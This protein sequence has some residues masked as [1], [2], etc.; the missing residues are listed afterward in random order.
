MRG[1]LY[2]TASSLQSCPGFHISSNLALVAGE[3][4]VRV[5]ISFPIENTAYTGREGL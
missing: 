4:L 2:A 1:N 3:D 5:G